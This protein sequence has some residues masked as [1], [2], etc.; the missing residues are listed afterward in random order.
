MQVSQR[1]RDEER[2]PD[3]GLIL[4][5]SPGFLPSAECLFSDDLPTMLTE[6]LP[7][8]RVLLLVEVKRL[9]ILEPGESTESYEKKIVR[10]LDVKMRKQV[11][12]QVR[13]TF[14]QYRNQETIVHLSAVGDYCKIR[15][16]NREAMERKELVPE[17][18]TNRDLTPDWHEMTTSTGV[19]LLRLVRPG[20]KTIHQ[21]LK[22][23]LTKNRKQQL[24]SMRQQHRA[25]QEGRR[26]TVQTSSPR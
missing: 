13:F 18:P 9:P 14:A 7:Y 15:W 5:Y 10:I 8:L 12:Q 22:T 19:Q 26:N 24:D 20:T 16:F 21:L 3:W 2:H 17:N 6:R 1:T 25:M 23:A 11:Y 4:A